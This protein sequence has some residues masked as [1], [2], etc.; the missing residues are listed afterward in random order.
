MYIYLLK[1]NKVA[2]VFLL[3]GGN[4]G[5]RMNFLNQADSMISKSIGEIVKSS[6][7]YESEPWGFIDSN[8]F[9][10]KVNKVITLLSPEDLLSAIHKIE[11]SLGR[12]RVNNKYQSRTI[13]I[14]ILFYDDII[15][16]AENL[17][18][19]HPH[20]HKRLFTL[21]PMMEIEPDYIH[22]LLKSNITGLFKNCDDSGIVNIFS[23]A[24]E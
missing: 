6:S 13:D 8:R 3:T 18:I 10:N 23:S 21:L 19:P 22:P 17:L 7:V 24:D 1:T 2:D 20:L 12:T 15:Y 11:K 16:N 9:L 4:Q 5:D 14:D